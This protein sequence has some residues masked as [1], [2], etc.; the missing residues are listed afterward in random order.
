MR[1]PSRGYKQAVIA[2]A[3]R[4]LSVLRAFI[5]DGRTVETTAPP[6]FLALG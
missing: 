4:R 5:R 3:R 1:R 2:L 6:S